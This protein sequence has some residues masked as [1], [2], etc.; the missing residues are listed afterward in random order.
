MRGIVI[1]I[2]IAGVLLQPFRSVFSL[3]EY[4]LN[5]PFI[6]RVLCENRDKPAMHCNG[7]CH[8]RKQLQQDDQKERTNSG[9]VKEKQTPDLMGDTAIIALPASPGQ[10]SYRQSS[11]YLTALPGGHLR[12]PFQPPCC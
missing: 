6:A 3:W 1:F 10:P 5:Q 2:I 7:K 4:E 8:L 12:A 11:W 9:G